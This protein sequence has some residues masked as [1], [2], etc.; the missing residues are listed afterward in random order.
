MQ[1]KPLNRPVLVNAGGSPRGKRYCA[2]H[3]DVAFPIVN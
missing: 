3:C 2:E 1:P